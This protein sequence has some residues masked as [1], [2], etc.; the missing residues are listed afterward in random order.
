MR[1]NIYKDYIIYSIYRM[2]EIPPDIAKKYKTFNIPLKRVIKDVDEIEVKIMDAVRRT[3][4]IVIHTY[5][6]IRLWILEKYHQNIELPKITENTFKL[7]FRALCLHPKGNSP[8]GDNLKLYEEFVKFN[9]ETYSKLEYEDK[10]DTVNLSQVLG[11]M[12]ID[13]KTNYENNIRMHFF[14]YIKRFVNSYFKEENDKI[15]EELKGKE[16]TEKRK[17]LNKE[18]YK[19]K[20]DLLENTTE[21]NEKYHKWLKEYRYKIL[22]ETFEKSYHYDIHID[23]NRYLKHMIFM[24]LELEK[25]EKKTFQIFPLR[26]SIYPKFIQID[27]AILI[28]LVV[29]K[30]KENKNDKVKND[31]L[32]NI[33]EHKDEFWNKY[34]NLKHKIFNKNQYT[35]DSRIVTDG[36]TVSIP[37]VHKYFI[38]KDKVKKANLKEGKKYIKEMTKDMSKEQKKE[39]KLKL[40][41]KKKDD[42]KKK[43]EEQIKTK[44]KQPTLKELT[45][46]MNKK[47]KEEFKKKLKEEKEIEKLLKIEQAKNKKIIEFPYLDELSNKELEKVKDVNKIYND[48]GKRYL[49]CMMDDK[50]FKFRYSNRQYMAETKRLKYQ[51]RNKNHKDNKGI[52][53]IE[54]ELT[55]FNS[56]SCNLDKFKDFIKKKNEINNK[57]FADYENERFRKY[58][59]YAY[60]NKNRALDNLL[61]TLEKIFGKNSNIIY[62]DWSISKQMRNYISTPGIGLKRKIKERFGIYN[63]DEFRTSCINHKTNTLCENLYLPDKKNIQRKLH[64]VLTYQMENKRTECINRDWNSVNNMK[65]IVDYW[66]IHK[67]R[68]EKFRRD[69]DI[70]EKKEE[71]KKKS[72][73]KSSKNSKTIKA[74]NLSSSG[75]MPSGS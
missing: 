53:K 15:L 64:S 25:L 21:C 75:G 54:N 2:D 33:E 59:F 16:K 61:T 65:N 39:Y 28:D 67:E 68:P 43:R 45:K 73:S 74:S 52:S 49:L 23:C 3:N 48:P 24:V 17:E 26:T 47:D 19:L 13:M 20:K 66:F 50:G 60:I 46:G 40:E 57:L 58:K 38:E 10:I 4:K 31:Y 14:D 56:K 1:L 5:Q 69:Y 27:T 51:E 7:A 44:E 70:K 11:Y 36:Y 8:K 35:F 37:L 9:N 62:G 42:T 41:N 18:L 34:F 22:P 32:H 71:I 63:L 72:K 55:D 12:A 6:F 30:D 29:G